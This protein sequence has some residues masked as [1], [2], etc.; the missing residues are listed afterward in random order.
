MT[1]LMQFDC[2]IILHS[3]NSVVLSRTL[4]LNFDVQVKRYPD[5]RLGTYLTFGS[6]FVNYCFIFQAECFSV[7][8]WLGKLRKQWPQD[9]KSVSFHSTCQRKAMPKNNHC[10]HHHSH[11]SKS[12]VSVPSHFI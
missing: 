6:S 8:Y 3:L 4:R 12:N 7:E 9:W 10:T 2:I 11:A 1:V 5:L